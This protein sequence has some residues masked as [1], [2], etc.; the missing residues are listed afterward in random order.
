MKTGES[1]K[2]IPCDD[3]NSRPRC[4][5]GPMLLFEKTCGSKSTRFFACAAFRS[6]NEC[7]FYLPADQNIPKKKISELEE[8]C[9]TFVKISILDKNQ[10]LKNLTKNNKVNSNIFCHSCTNLIT[11]SEVNVGHKGHNIEASVSLENLKKPTRLLRSLKE[12]TKEAQYFFSEQSSRFILSTLSRLGARTVISI[13]TPSLVEKLEPTKN[14]Y[15]LDFDWRYGV[16]YGEQFSWYNMFN[17][18]FL[19]TVED[20]NGLESKARF[21]SFLNNLP[22]EEP[23]C[24]LLDPPFGGRVEPIVWTLK[25]LVSEIRETGCVGDVYFLWVFPYFMEPYIVNSLPGTSM[26]DYRID[27]VDHKMFN[28]A[29]RRGRK[30]G[31]PVRIFTNAPL[32]LIVHPVEEGY[33]FCKECQKYVHESNKHC[34]FCGTCPSKAGGT[35]KHCDKCERCVKPNWLHCASCSKCVTK[36]HECLLKKRKEPDVLFAKNRKKQ[37]KK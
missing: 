20:S 2:V 25:K 29:S 5:H 36:T 32:H 3:N 28:S 24:I 17:H 1:H 18:H 11:S 10:R 23:V 15:L 22:K 21:G 34:N 35:Y 6:R 12:T 27:Y 14:F 8:R 9:K 33:Q 37:A 16:F 30:T 19:E 4:P 13:G 31:S 26:L 7:Q